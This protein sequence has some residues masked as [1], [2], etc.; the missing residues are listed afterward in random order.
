MVMRQESDIA[1]RLVYLEKLIEERKTAQPVPA[2]GISSF[3]YYTAN[4]YDFTFTITAASPSAAQ[5]K[6]FYTGN[7]KNVMY[8]MRVYVR[9]DNPDVM[10]DPLPYQTP[11]APPVYVRWAR[12]D[13]TGDTMTFRI[14]YTKNNPGVDSYQV[15]V[16]YVL[17]GTAS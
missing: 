13:Y 7:S 3:K 14:Q 5:Y 15:Y 16:K 4:Q 1:D 6:T 12:Y 2:G 10:A 17:Y 11:S 8:R 9:I